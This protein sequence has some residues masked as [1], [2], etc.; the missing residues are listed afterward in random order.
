[1]AALD[2]PAEAELL[3]VSPK[4][5]TRLAEPNLIHEC[6]SVPALW[7]RVRREVGRDPRTGLRMKLMEPEPVQ[8]RCCSRGETLTHSGLQRYGFV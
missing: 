7:D 1:M 4:R 2:D 3:H 6:Q 8:R 5:P